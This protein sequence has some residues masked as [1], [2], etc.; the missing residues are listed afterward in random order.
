MSFAL[1]ARNCWHIKSLSINNMLAFLLLAE[2]DY[3]GFMVR[4]KK[5]Q[6]CNSNI[7]QTKKV[8]GAEVACV[9]VKVS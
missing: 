1:R 8:K 2:M 6:I 4:R 5:L 7:K 3:F 9:K